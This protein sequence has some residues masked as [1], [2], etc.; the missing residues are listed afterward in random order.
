MNGV[1]LLAWIRVGNLGNGIQSLLSS[2]LRQVGALRWEIQQGGEMRL[3]V[4]RDLGHRPL[5]WETVLSSPFIT[6]ERFGQWVLVATT[7]D[8]TTVRHY[9]NGRLIGTGASFQPPALLLGPASICNWSGQS[10][11]HLS[12]DV[13]EFAV[14]SRVMS[15]QEIHDFYERGKP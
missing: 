12:A 11:R 10:L 1:T 2:D 7:F 14:L 13:D 8:G 6:R 5:D 4:G 3:A 15:A 9:G